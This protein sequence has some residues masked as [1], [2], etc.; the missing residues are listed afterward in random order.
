M[1]TN[2]HARHAG[3]PRDATAD[4]AI[5]R[6]TLALIA[7]VGVP[8]VTVSEVAR[9]AGVARATVYLRWSSR[10]GLVGAA[11]K[12][13][14]GGKPF[15]ASGDLERDVR[16]GAE[17]IRG[18]V[19]A[20]YFSTMLPELMRAVLASP[21]EVSFDALA[22]NRQIFAAEYRTQAAA[23]GFDPGIDPYLFF[24]TLFGACLV[25]LFAT[26]LAP[27]KAYVEQLAEVIVRGLRAPRPAGAEPA[28][29]GATIS[30]GT[31][32]RGTSAAAR[33]RR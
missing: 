15:A 28:S 22:P 29:T 23:Q 10:A 13:V 6:A 14:V 26:Q 4:A 30:T 7:E 19:G 33:A 17:F 21:P 3:R 1:T 25:H 16:D 9:R 8:G 24:D 31:G 5:L 18:V 12:A 27:S 11:T 32:A 2:E 20:H